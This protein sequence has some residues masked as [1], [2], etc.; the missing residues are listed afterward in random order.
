MRQALYN[1]FNHFSRP[2][3]FA[4]KTRLKRFKYYFLSTKKKSICD[5]FHEFALRH[6]DTYMIQTAILKETTTTR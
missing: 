2:T 4:I 6:A 5:G 3:S 1:L